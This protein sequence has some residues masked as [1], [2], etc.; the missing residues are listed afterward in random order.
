M[1]TIKF[2]KPAKIE[3]QERIVRSADEV[4]YSFTD[5]GESVIAKIY[6]GECGSP[7]YLP[8]WEGEE[9]EKAGQYTDD[10]IEGRITELLTKK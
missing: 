4:K 7:T 6:E 2:K 8:L 10:D 5:D 9:Y 1:R 3:V